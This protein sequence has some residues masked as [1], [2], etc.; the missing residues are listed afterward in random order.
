MKKALQRNARERC[1]WFEL[2]PQSQSNEEAHEHVVE[3]ASSI[4]EPR[5]ELNHSNNLYSIV[6]RRQLTKDLFLDRRAFLHS[7]D[8]A[9]DPQG[10][11]MVRILSA[12]IPVCGGI[13]L[14][15]LFSRIDNSVYGAGTKLPHNVIGLLGVANGVEG[16]LRTGLPSQMIEVHEPARLMIVVEQSRDILN[17]TFAKLGALKEWLDNDWVRL[18]SCHPESRELFLYSVNG[19]ESVELPDDFKV[20]QA[21]IS[22]S[23]IVGQ[24]KTIPVHHFNRRHA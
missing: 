16:D 21:R 17:K 20:P 14:E 6:G 15:Y 3:R 24:T 12:V 8:P 4:F 5:P 23:I 2:G 1:R 18:V 7:Y 13:N 19:W 10:D 9:S 22:E 11:I